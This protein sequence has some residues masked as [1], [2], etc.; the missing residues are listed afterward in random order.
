MFQRLGGFDE[1]FDRGGAARAGDADP[2]YRL[3]RAGYRL[4][5]DRSGRVLRHDAAAMLR[6]SRECGR[7]AVAL[8][9]KHPELAAPLLGPGRQGPGRH[10]AARRLG[11][12]GPRVAGL[13]TAAL[14]P[15]AVRR[16]GPAELLEAVR[17]VGYWRGVAEAGGVPRTRPLRVL[18]YHAI[19]D[20]AGDPVVEAYG[21]PPARFRRQLDSLRR[22]GYGSSTPTSCWPSS[23]AGPACPGGRCC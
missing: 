15:L 17:E 8:V 23:T 9:R 14:A 6:Q 12:A 2:G 3:L 5:F 20:L 19:S 21:V 16:A 7:A 4:R 18:C 11:L 13:A 1:R 10:P 22:A